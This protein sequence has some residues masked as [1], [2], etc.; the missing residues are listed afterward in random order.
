VLGL[1][2]EEEA[3]C[4]VLDVFNTDLVTGWPVRL[5]IS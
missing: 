5:Q 2:T 1:Q 4:E 3:R